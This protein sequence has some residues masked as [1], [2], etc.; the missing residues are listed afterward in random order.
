MQ[1]GLIQRQYVSMS[2]NLAHPV[3]FF[4]IK[5]Q[6]LYGAMIIYG[7]GSESLSRAYESHYRGLRCGIWRGLRWGSD[8]F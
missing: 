8:G 1:Y 3:S 4:E 2:D 5:I 7:I 6:Y